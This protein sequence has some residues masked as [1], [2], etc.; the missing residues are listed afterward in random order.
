MKYPPTTFSP[1]SRPTR[2]DLLVRAASVTWGFLWFHVAALKLIQLGDPGLAALRDRLTETLGQ[3]SRIEGE[4]GP[5]LTYA[6]GV[7]SIASQGLISGLWFR[8]VLRKRGLEN[9]PRPVFANVLFLVGSAACLAVC[10]QAEEVRFALTLVALS[11]LTMLLDGEPWDRPPGRRSDPARG[12][13]HA[14]SL[15]AH[16]GSQP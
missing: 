11:L 8:E 16:L 13:T 4:I 6:F 1:P 9:L 12:A 5:S 15:P 10:G 14:R 2:R 7:A 3:F